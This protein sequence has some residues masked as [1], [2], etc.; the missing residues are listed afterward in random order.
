M[1]RSSETI[2]LLDRSQRGKM[3]ENEV[4]CEISSPAPKGAFEYDRSLPYCPNKIW[5]PFKNR[6]KI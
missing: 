1:E 3:C 4:I 6:K 5:Q 2:E